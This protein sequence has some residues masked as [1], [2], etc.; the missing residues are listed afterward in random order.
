MFVS[1]IAI[2]AFHLATGFVLAL[3]AEWLWPRAHEAVPL[4]DPPA[5]AVTTPAQPTP[6]PAAVEQTPAAPPPSD[7]S[8]PPADSSAPDITAENAHEIPPEWHDV[9]ANVEREGFGPCNS[10]V[11]SSTQAV[12]LEAATYRAELLNLDTRLRQAATASD[13]PPLA[14]IASQL[15]ALNA[16]WLECQTTA[17][18]HL[19][20]R[21]A[22]AGR[23]AST[24][25]DIATALREQQALIESAAEKTRDLSAKDAIPKLLAEIGRLVDLTH[26]LR[27]RLHASL[28]MVLRAE[29][30][31]LSLDRGLQ[32]DTK[33]GLISRSGLEVTLEQW[34]RDDPHHIRTLAVLLVDI[35]SM[36]K[37]N[38]RFGPAMGDAMASAVGRQ[39]DAALRK[40]RGFDMLARYDG[41][42]FVLLLGDIGPGNATSAAARF[43]QVIGDSTFQIAGE[44]APVQ[45]RIGITMTLADDTIDKLFARLAATVAIAKGGGDHRLA[46][47]E[48]GGPKIIEQPPTYELKGQVIEL[49]PPS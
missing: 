38:E 29:D 9:L 47:D 12:R 44:D 6:E 43:S 26:V 46:I 24:S 10:F 40:K 32:I 19:A 4:T 27:D 21:Q 11:E 17:A 18:G 15:D 30:R 2:V 48:G 1:V 37:F 39:I 31:L 13:P 5:V 25:K 20:A 16:R 36:A 42:S 41:Q 23:H 35:E 45:V 28:L 33:S 14:E 3:V 34:W 8:N 22:H 7:E 49:N